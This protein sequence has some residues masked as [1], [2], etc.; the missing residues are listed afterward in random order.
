VEHH[1]ICTRSLQ[2]DD[3]LL[4]LTKLSFGESDLQVVC[5]LCMMIVMVR[6]KDV[7]WYL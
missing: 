2:D 1:W 6:S 7:N 4:K 3:E 5:F